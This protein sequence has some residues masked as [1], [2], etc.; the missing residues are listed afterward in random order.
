MTDWTSLFVKIGTPLVAL[1]LVRSVWCSL[2]KGE[3]ALGGVRF[4]R[5][6]NPIGFWLVVSFQVLVIGFFVMLISDVF[7]GLDLRFWL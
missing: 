1:V 4:N 2:L 5:S 7:F 3:T 6:R